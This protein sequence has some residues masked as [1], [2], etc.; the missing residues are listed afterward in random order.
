[1][2]WPAPARLPPGLALTLARTPLRLVDDPRLQHAHALPPRLKEAAPSGGPLP[3]APQTRTPGTPCPPVRPHR[4]A[5]QPDRS[6]RVLARRRQSATADRCRHRAGPPAARAGAGSARTSGCCRPNPASGGTSQISTTMR[7][8]SGETQPPLHEA[9]ARTSSKSALR[10]A[11]RTSTLSCVLRTPPG[12]DDSRSGVRSSCR[13]FGSGARGASQA[14]LV[15]LVDGAR[16]GG[17]SA[18]SFASVARSA[19]CCCSRP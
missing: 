1:M 17:S 9:L 7:R 11:A 14:A 12:L 5:E 8:Q 19:C 2:R 18:C 6:P 15:V 10:C 4:R 16:P 13:S 3:P